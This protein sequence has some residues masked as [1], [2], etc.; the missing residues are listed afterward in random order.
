[1][2]WYEFYA[3]VGVPLILLAFAFGLLKIDERDTRRF[4]EAQARALQLG[5]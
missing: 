5:E 3:Y 2:S 1:M 4:E